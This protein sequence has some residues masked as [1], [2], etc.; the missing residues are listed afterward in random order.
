MQTAPIVHHLY[1]DLPVLTT[2]FKQETNSGLNSLTWFER[3][4]LQVKKIL[5]LF[6]VTFIT[7]FRP[8]AHTQCQYTVHIIMCTFSCRGIL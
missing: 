5:F 7:C 2:T 1:I 3:Q 4:Q 6:L 8:P